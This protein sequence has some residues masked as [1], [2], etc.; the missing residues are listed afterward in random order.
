[1]TVPFDR[2]F[3]LL[4]GIG[5]FLIGVASMLSGETFEPGRF[6]RGRFI[7]RSEE[8]KRFWWNVVGYL[9]VGL[10]F[11]GLYLAQISN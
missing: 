1:M 7:E 8:P 3:F 11:A 10:F 4:F 9:L 6:G 2:R 5:I